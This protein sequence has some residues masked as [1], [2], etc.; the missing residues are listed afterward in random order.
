A[1][2]YVTDILAGTAPPRH[3]LRG[4]IAFK[5]GTSYGYR[6]AWSVGYDGRHVIGV[7]V[8]RPDGS[9]VPGLTG[10][11]VAAPVLFESFA[12]L[13]PG[14]YAPLSPAPEGALI[15]GNADLPL[16]LRHFGPARPV[17]RTAR[18][19]TLDIVYPPDQA[20]V[21]LGLAAPG[22]E[23][24]PLVVKIKGGKPPFIWF[25]NGALIARVKHRRSVR[26]MPDSSGFSSLTVLDARGK[27]DSV[28]VLLE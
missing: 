27:T 5:T 18:G 16:P 8:G 7:W 23:R 13:S 10:R 22:G 17:S 6:D 9:S 3:A 11:R 12:R 2:W 20:R 15:A 4:K 25:A 28:S 14:G 1:A 26:W 21:D 19:R 24:M